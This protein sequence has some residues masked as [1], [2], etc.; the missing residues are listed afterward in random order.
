MAA[1]DNEPVIGGSR[2]TRLTRP[3]IPRNHAA[4]SNMIQEV[5]RITLMH[6]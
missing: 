6:V 5:A 4:E 3:D 2:T 1:I